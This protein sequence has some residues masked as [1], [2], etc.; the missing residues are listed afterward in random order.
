MH[1][2]YGFDVT[3]DQA[4]RVLEAYDDRPDR[5][6]DIK[7]YEECTLDEWQAH[8]DRFIEQEKNMK[9]IPLAATVGIF[10][11]N[12]QRIK[13]LFLPSP[14]RCLDEIH[15]LMPRIAADLTAKLLAETSH[16][17]ERLQR[18]PED[19]AE[20]VD[21]S[22]FLRTTNERQKEFGDRSGA[23]ARFTRRPRNA[24]SRP[25]ARCSSRSR[26]SRPASASRSSRRTSPACPRTSSS[27]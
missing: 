13:D 5:L 10:A 15:L 20:F 26:S 19:V 11:G 27:S 18:N 6:L 1:G 8:M 7:E 4:G 14:R 2:R 21:Y 9:A 25:S 23:T 3:S 22:E 16:A 12:N 24:S 17:Q